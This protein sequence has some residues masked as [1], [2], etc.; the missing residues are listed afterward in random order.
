MTAASTR[1][2]AGALTGCAADADKRAGNAAL[3]GRSP[4]GRVDGYRQAITL[5]ASG[6]VQAADARIANDP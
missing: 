2:W 5:L 1:G 3:R 4:R 6:Q